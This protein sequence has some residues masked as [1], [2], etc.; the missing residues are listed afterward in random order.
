MSLPGFR[1]FWPTNRAKAKTGFHCCCYLVQQLVFICIWVKV[2]SCFPGKSLKNIHLLPSMLTNDACLHKNQSFQ[3][4][5]KRRCSKTPSPFLVLYLQ[6]QT[7]ETLDF[8]L[9]QHTPQLPDLLPAWTRLGTINKEGR[10]PSPGVSSRQRWGFKTTAGKTR[11]P[12]KP[13]VI[14]LE[15]NWAPLHH[16]SPCGCTQSPLRMVGCRARRC[17]RASQSQRGS[18][19]GFA[20]GTPAWF[21]PPPIHLW[22]LKRL[23]LEWPSC[24]TPWG[25]MHDLVKAAL[26]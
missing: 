7:P 4:H 14:C 26:S 1:F 13:R 9:T 5:N 21:R 25:V 8:N 23:P 10:R 24:G 22:P 19:R 3:F 18:W 12:S 6:S 16:V 20:P 17:A 11:R 2:S 15:D